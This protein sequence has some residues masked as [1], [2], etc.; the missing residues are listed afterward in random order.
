[1]ENPDS[2]SSKEVEISKNISLDSKNRTAKKYFPASN[3]RETPYGIDN[4]ATDYSNQLHPKGDLNGIKL[5]KNEDV[6]LQRKNVELKPLDKG[7]YI[8][9]L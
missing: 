6:L 3:S 1:M 9:R 7:F 5:N 8:I 4:E 2:E